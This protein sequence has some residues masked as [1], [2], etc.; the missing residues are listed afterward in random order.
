MLAATIGSASA[1]VAVL[2]LAGVIDTSIVVVA[3]ACITVRA[4]AAAWAVHPLALARATSSVLPLAAVCAV[5][6]WRSGST[7][8]DAIR[9]ANTI[10]GPAIS[11]TPVILAAAMTAAALSAILLAAAGAV[12][13][14]SAASPFARSLDRVGL[15]L[16]AL[17]VVTAAGGPDADDAR[18]LLAW[19]AGVLIVLLLM[20]I[21]ERVA[22]HPRAV[23]A[24]TAAGALAV[25]L[26]ALR[27]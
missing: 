16:T 25:V 24:A 4:A 21:A 15:L 19:T 11:T 5:A 27:G 13:I 8:L 3:F 7:Q 22:V 6:A 23:H 26:G 17:L 2:A 9:G 20:R 18:S 1:I 14:A 12:A 10:L